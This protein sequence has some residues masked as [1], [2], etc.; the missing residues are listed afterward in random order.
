[1]RLFDI[2]AIGA[3]L[4]A[5]AWGVPM[6]FY[7]FFDLKRSKQAVHATVRN[8]AGSL[9]LFFGFL[10]TMIGLLVVVLPAPAVNSGPV[11][12]PLV[13]TGFGVLMF[14]FGFGTL[15][16]GTSHVRL[17]ASIWFFLGA[18]YTVLGIVLFF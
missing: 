7:G 18:L 12:G 17:G 14:R 9:L 1:M 3:L 6:L 4:V 13:V 8:L 5:W 10:Y 2:G 15:E 11:T 16:R